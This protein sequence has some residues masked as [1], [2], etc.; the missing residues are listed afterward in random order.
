MSQDLQTN[1]YDQLI[2]RVGG[3]YGPGSK[4]TEVIPDVMPVIDLE[5]V[6][7]ELLFLQGWRIG[8]GGSSLIAIVGETP[9]HQ[10]FNPVGS[11]KLV[12]VTT[13]LWSTDAAEAI[14]MTLSA[15]PLATAVGNNIFRDSRSG[16]AE[17]TTAQV[18]NE[19]SVTGTI[20]TTTFRCLSNTPW[21]LQDPNGIA[22]LAPG[23]GL[24]IGLGD[25]NGA[26]RGNFFWRERVA[27][28]SELLFP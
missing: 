9:K 22:V 23:T 6:P 8:M 1:R 11:G 28:E 15:I 26:L 24:N 4:V 3:L 16:V 10:L 5:R 14:E 7:S 2:R 12:V 25:T 18:R 21:T 13:V 19:S 17:A 27:L 20:G